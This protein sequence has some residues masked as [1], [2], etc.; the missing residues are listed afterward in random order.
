MITHISV[1]CTQIGPPA[2][3]GKINGRKMDFGPTGKKGEKWTK[4][5]EKW[6]KN[7]PQTWPIFPFFGRFFPSSGWGPFFPISGR[8]GLYRAIGIATLHGTSVA[9]EFFCVVSLQQLSWRLSR[10]ARSHC[11]GP[12]NPSPHPFGGQM[13][14]QEA[15]LPSPDPQVTRGFCNRQNFMQC[16]AGVWKA[17]QNLPPDPIPALDKTTGPMGERFLS[18]TGVRFAVL[19]GR[20]QILLAP[21]LDKNR[22]RG[23]PCR[24][25]R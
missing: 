22:W 8:G 10:E 23:H 24:A 20:A 2:R 19:I 18:S 16:G 17:F 21:A 4:K 13:P 15:G 3:N 25:L 5:W 7:G 6:A 11:S 9:Q 12:L 14:S 1:V